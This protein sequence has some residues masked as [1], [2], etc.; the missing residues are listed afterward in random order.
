MGWENRTISEIEELTDDELMKISEFMGYDEFGEYLGRVQVGYKNRK[1][2]ANSAYQRYCGVFNELKQIPRQWYAQFTSGLDILEDIADFFDEDKVEEIPTKAINAPAVV[3]FKMSDPKPD[4]VIVYAWLRRGELDF[5]KMKLKKYDKQALE[6]WVDSKTWKDHL[7]DKRYFKKLTTEFKKFGVGLV[8]K[9]PTD[10]V[11][12]AT[13]WLKDRPLIQ[14]SDSSNDL[15]TCYHSLFHE[16][17]HVVIHG[18]DDIP[19]DESL[20]LQRER[21]ADEYAESRLGYSIAV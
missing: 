5:N 11:H 14:V 17:A 19:K 10:G 21:E 8:S 12:G 16:I 13:R 1:E 7:S 18:Q 4:P 2:K 3:S 9:Y 20:L 6:D 15:H